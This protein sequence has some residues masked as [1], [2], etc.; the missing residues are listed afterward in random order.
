MEVPKS[1]QPL[2][3]NGNSCHSPQTLQ[4]VIREIE[5]MQRQPEGEEPNDDMDG[6]VPYWN[7]NDAAYNNGLEDVLSLLSKL[8]ENGYVLL[9][10]DDIWW[11]KIPKTHV[12]IPKADLLTDDEEWIITSSLNQNMNWHPE[13]NTE[14][15]MLRKLKNLT[16][17]EG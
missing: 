5:K 10:K 2:A 7:E 12:L 14:K 9:K 13:L 4:D 11:K 16:S 6:T 17:K 3:V 1:G 8:A 15:R